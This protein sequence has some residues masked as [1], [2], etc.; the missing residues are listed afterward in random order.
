MTTRTFQFY[1]QGWGSETAEITVTLNGQT[2]FSGAIPTVPERPPITPGALDPV[3]LFTGGEIDTTQTGLFPMTVTATKGNVV[4]CEVL[5]NYVLVPNPIYTPEQ[6]AVVTD[7]TQ[8]EAAQVI[9]V[10]KA[11][12]AF[13]AEE[14][15]VLDN[16][17][18]YSPEAQAICAEHQCE[19]YV[20]GPEYFSAAF[21]NGD[22]RYDVVIDGVPQ[23]TPEPRPEGLGG[24]WYWE[25]ETNQTMT[26]NLNISP[27][28][29]LQ[30]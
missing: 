15:D 30:I 7:W 12:P 26:Y 2:I 4:M 13:T 20:S 11:N 16:Y 14:I 17:A 24:D 25:V 3:L 1:G 8:P 5:G 29:P 18:L 21:N 6:W 19:L 23:T 9:I 28:D 22:S 27:V 10:S